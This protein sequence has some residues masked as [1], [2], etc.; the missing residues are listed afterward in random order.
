MR[1]IVTALRTYYSTLK[2]LRATRMAQER[3]DFEFEPRTLRVALRQSYCLLVSHHWLSGIASDPEQESDCVILTNECL[4]CGIT[5]YD[6]CLTH[7]GFS[8]VE[9]DDHEE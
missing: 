4:R 2:A 1:A 5:R 3:R 8:Y 7:A 9:W 6:E